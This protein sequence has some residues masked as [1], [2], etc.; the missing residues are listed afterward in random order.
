MTYTPN[1]KYLLIFYKEKHFFA[2][3]NEIVFSNIS[4]VNVKLVLKHFKYL[5]ETQQR[6]KFISLY[7]LWRLV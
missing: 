6:E 1:N 3:S 4:V 7:S 2:F 5:N